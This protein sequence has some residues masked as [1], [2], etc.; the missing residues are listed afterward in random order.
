M[1]QQQPSFSPDRFSGRLG[2][3]FDIF[4]HKWLAW[5]RIHDVAEEADEKRQDL[6]LLALEHG[7]AAELWLMSQP[8]HYRT[9]SRH[10]LALLQSRFASSIRIEMGR[11][12]ASSAL[13]NRGF[14]D[15]QHRGECVIDLINNFEVLAGVARIDDDAQRRE[16]FIWSFRQYSGATRMLQKTATLEATFEEALRWEKMLV[17]KTGLTP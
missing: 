6:L 11:Q 5:M 16:L 14:R 10:T 12:A 13:Q 15:D 4:L 17:E 2:D 3:D 9:T 7:S 8:S 1:N